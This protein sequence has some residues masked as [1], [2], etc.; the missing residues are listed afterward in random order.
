VLLPKEYANFRCTSVGACHK[1]PSKYRS[2]DYVRQLLLH[3]RT[4]READAKAITFFLRSQGM[5]GP[6]LSGDRL[7][8]LP[9]MFV[10]GV[11]LIVLVKK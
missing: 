9:T 3:H 4:G 10:A 5:C 6:S 1:N 11:T 7:A 2:L 8:Q